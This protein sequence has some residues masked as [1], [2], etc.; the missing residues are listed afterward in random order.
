[1]K[2]FF[3]KYKKLIG[4]I[5]FTLLCLIVWRIGIH[6]KFPFANYDSIPSTGGGNIFGFLDV[7]AGGGLTQFSILSLGIRHF[8]FNPEAEFNLVFFLQKLL[9]LRF[10]EVISFC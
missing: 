2:K 9:S 10:P 6:I 1:M 5:L 4:M 7:F 8:R 3:G